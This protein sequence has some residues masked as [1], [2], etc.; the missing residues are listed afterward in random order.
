MVNIYYINY[1]MYTNTSK[2]IYSYLVDILD[3]TYLFRLDAF[4]LTWNLKVKL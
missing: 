2:H 1:I 3:T 4:S